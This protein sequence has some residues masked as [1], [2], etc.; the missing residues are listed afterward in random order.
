MT[1]IERIYAADTKALVVT[2]YRQLLATPAAERSQFQLKIVREGIAE[3]AK[4][5][6]ERFVKGAWVH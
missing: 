1:T 5:T 3:I 2:H 4:L 6:G